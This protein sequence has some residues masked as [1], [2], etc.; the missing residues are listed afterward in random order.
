MINITKV[1]KLI[2]SVVIPVDSAPAYTMDLEEYQNT[3]STMVTKSNHVSHPIR[4]YF[5][6][7]PNPEYNFDDLATTYGTWWEYFVY[8]VKKTGGIASDCAVISVAVYLAAHN[9]LGV[10]F[11]FKLKLADGRDILIEV[12]G[13]GATTSSVVKVNDISKGFYLS[14]VND[15]V[16]ERY[17]ILFAEEATHK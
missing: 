1:V 10:T 14:K 7:I 11:T 4:F 8:S 13:V 6:A 16:M 9:T 5:S 12:L 15:A 3:I 17:D 2:S